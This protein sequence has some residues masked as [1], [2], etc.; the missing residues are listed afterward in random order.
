MTDTEAQKLTLDKKEQP[1]PTQQSLNQQTQVQ[2]PQKTTTIENK[3]QNQKTNIQTQKTDEVEKSYP[4][5]QTYKSRLIA[6]LEKY[7]RKRPITLF[8]PEFID[9]T[10]SEKEQL[11]MEE[12]YDKKTQREKSLQEEEDKKREKE[13]QKKQ[14]EG[15]NYIQNQPNLTNNQIFR[16]LD[17]D[18]AKFAHATKAYIDQYYKIS[19]MFVCCPLYYN[20][21]I[22]LLYDKIPYFLF[23]TK[24]Y[25]PVCSHDCCPNQSR[26]FD[27]EIRS[28]SIDEKFMRKRF[29]TI[30]KPFRCACSCLC[31]CCSRPKLEVKIN[32]G[33]E[34]IGKVVEIRTLCTPTLYI[35]NKSNYVKYRIDGRC[36]QSGYCC[37]DLCCGMYNNCTFQIYYGGEDPDAKVVGTINKLKMSGKKRK[38]DFEQ[39]EVTFPVTASC[40]DKVLIISACLFLEMLYFQNIS[41]KNRCHGDPI[42]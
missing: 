23:D 9:I 2:N 7:G 17:D 18:L 32:G 34:Y 16:T 22:S 19:D 15:E 1:Q 36:S 13:L 28:Y 26:T 6:A 38:P 5:D 10:K 40:Y 30:N 42:D 33:T 25:S 11:K 41:N 29:A 12:A 3:N 27:M 20:Y 4:I 8:E 37:K 35:F 21:R 14:T 31:A 39:V 24:E